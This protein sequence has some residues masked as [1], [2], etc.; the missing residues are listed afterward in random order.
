MKVLDLQC[1]QQ[2]RFEGWF[3]S[4]NDFADQLGKGLVGCPVCAS[5]TITKLLSAPRLS[6]GHHREAADAS[7][8]KQD[9]VATPASPEL[10]LQAAW[11]TMARRIVASTDDVGDSFAEEARKMHYGEAEQRGIRGKASREETEALMEEG[12][13]VMPLPL[14]EAFKGQLQ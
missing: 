3:A 14:P 9:V 4:E 11:L 1:D 2:H 5:T 8:T 12:I 13:E 10:A 7:S 6:L